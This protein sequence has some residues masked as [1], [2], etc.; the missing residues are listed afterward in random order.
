M[1]RKPYT[2]PLS[3]GWW[4]HRPFYTRYMIR[5]LSSA[6]V[7]AYSGLLIVGLWR[8]SEGEQAWNGYVA[9]LTHPLA[10]V[11]QGVSLLFCLYHTITWFGVA[12]R[13]AP[14]MVG[15]NFVPPRPI[16]AAQYAAWGL[17]S[18]VILAAA[19]WA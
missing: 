10:L 6:F 17:A 8:L 18:A 4:L 15:E 13:T 1:S 7:T 14:V 9:A 11:F 16:I 5:E 19:L 2:P 12:P 3:Y